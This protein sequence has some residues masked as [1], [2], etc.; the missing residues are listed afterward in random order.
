MKDNRFNIKGL[1]QSNTI[2]TD[3]VKIGMNILKKQHA[4]LIYDLLELLQIQEHNARKQ[5]EFERR[6]RTM[7]WHYKF[8]RPFI[9]K[10]GEDDV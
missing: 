6:I 2:V 8:L 9:L 5:I 1:E 4:D 10:I 7:E 3:K